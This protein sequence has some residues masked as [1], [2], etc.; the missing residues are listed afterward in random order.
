MVRDFLQTYTT[1]L[2]NHPEDIS[3]EI[4]E[5]DEGFDEITIFANSEDVG[6][7][8][9]KEGR[10]INA[11]K[12]VISGCKAKGGKNYRVNVKAVD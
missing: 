10:M 9:G 11:I 12:T 4:E 5:M 6:K 7:L 8:I 2:V 1:L 3:I